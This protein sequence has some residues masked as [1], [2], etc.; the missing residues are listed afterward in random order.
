MQVIDIESSRAS[1]C[2]SWVRDGTSQ[3][4]LVSLSLRRFQQFGHLSA[5]RSVQQ[6][7]PSWRKVLGLY[8]K[9][10]PRLPVPI[11]LGDERI[12][13]A[14]GTTIADRPPHRTVR[15]VYALR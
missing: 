15:C 1:G 6:H 11:D 8:R 9:V 3:K 14:V 13:V 10:N 7:P 5:R 12:T 2:G 4:P